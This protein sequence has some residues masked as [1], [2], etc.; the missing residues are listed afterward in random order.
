MKQQPETI[1]RLFEQYL[2]ICNKAIE[3]HQ[4]AFP[5][6]HIWEAAEKLQGQNGMHVTIYDDEPKG[7]YLLRIH[8]KHIEVV[9]ESDTTPAPGW[10]MNT[11][12][13]KEVVENP[14]TYISEPAKLDWH[15]LKN[16]ME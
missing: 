1:H 15:W 12:Y 14:Q 7:D 13:L 2:D 4:N 8:D 16:R 3:A 10:R 6:K 9:N 5:Y 11:S